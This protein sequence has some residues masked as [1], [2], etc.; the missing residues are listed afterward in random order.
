AFGVDGT[1][2]FFTNVNIN[3]YW[4]KTRTSGLEG[5]DASYRAQLDYA[6]DRYGVQLEQLR[7]GDHFNPEVGFVRRDDMRCSYGQLRFSPRPKQSRTIRKFWYI[8]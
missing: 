7:V 5:D 6:A 1:F 2:T 4:A 3:T 8:G